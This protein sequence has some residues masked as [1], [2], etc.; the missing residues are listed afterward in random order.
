[1]PKWFTLDDLYKWFQSQQQSMVFSSEKECGNVIAVHVPC[2]IQFSKSSKDL[3]GLR[4]V[5]LQACHTEENSNGSYISE[6]VMKNA[7]PSFA[8]RPIL[9]F[10]HEVDG[11][12]EFFTHNMHIEN[13]ELVYDEFPVGIIPES[14]NAK[15][16]YDKENDKKYVVVEGYLFEGYSKAVEILQRHEKCWCS[17][18]LDIRE[19][20]Y[21]AGENRLQIE[22]FFFSGVTILGVDNDGNEVNPGMKGSNIKLAD[23][24]T[25]YSLFEKNNIENVLQELNDTL[26]KLNINLSRKEETEMPNED[27]I[28]DVEEEMVEEESFSS[29]EE[30]IA[31]ETVEEEQEEIIDEEE[32]ETNEEEDTSDES[33]EET[34][35]LN[36]IT[37]SITNGDINKCFSITLSEQLQALS[38]LVN[39]AYADI[40]GTYYSVDADSENKYVYMFDVYR[41]KAY[42]QNYKVKG[43]VFTLTGDRVEIF[44]I[45]VTEAE[46]KEFEKMKSRYSEIEDKLNKY[47]TEDDKL[48]I[49]HSDEYSSIFDNDAFK[50][51]QKKENYFNLTIEEVR[52]EA[53]TILLNAAKS[54]TIEFES[55]K[56]EKVSYK[57]VLKQGKAGKYGGIFK[58]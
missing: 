43:E 20:S 54:H 12:D 38:T 31:E 23:F 26:A 39:E 49:L 9:A 16:K 57:P 14:C 5:V 3:E 30:E 47:E 41:N 58:R 35:E 56:K 45:W 27:M 40:D 4:K 7:L 37:Y 51:L 55:D 28:Q 18:E 19:L 8:N 44:P 11:Q 32:E 17:V 6:K 34:F 53:D 33:T 36:S 21:D 25:G 50:D 22:D 29:E 24:A 10:I 52:E 1:M 15:I 48:A 13:D 2:D 42:R 46:K